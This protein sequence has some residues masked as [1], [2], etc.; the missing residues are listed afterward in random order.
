[1][2]DK[3]NSLPLFKDVGEKMQILAKFVC[4]IGI[5]ASLIGGGILFFVSFEEGEIAYFLGGIG[6]IIF[7]SLFSWISSWALLGFGKIVEN[8]EECMYIREKAA[9]STNSSATAP[10]AQTNEAEEIK[11]SFFKCSVC[12]N[13]ISENPCPHCNHNT[14]DDFR[15][16]VCQNI[17]SKNPCPYCNHNRDDD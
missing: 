15:C 3:F 7:G 6:A 17:I 11:E 13:I 14:D 8:A 1:M 2:F 12:K 10:T 9:K 4:C 16:S 5:I